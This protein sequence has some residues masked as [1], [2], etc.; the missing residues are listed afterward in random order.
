[1]QGVFGI[2]LVELFGLEKLTA[3]YGLSYFFQGK[4]MKFCCDIKRWK[5]RKKYCTIFPPFHLCRYWNSSW[6]SHNWLCSWDGK[7]LLR[8][9]FRRIAF[10]ALKSFQFLSIDPQAEK[11]L[12]QI[13]QR[14]QPKCFYLF[15]F[16]LTE[17]QF[18]RQK[19][20]IN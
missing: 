8:I 5:M 15:W 7:L 20:R 10:S 18:E 9:C 1:M 6:A 12:I 16:N 14:S 19:I 13:H 4:F 3:A 2:T 17:N 11:R